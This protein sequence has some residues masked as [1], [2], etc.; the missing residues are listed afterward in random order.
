MV[1]F[2]GPTDVR[3]LAERLGVR[4]AKRWG[5]NFVVDAGTVRRIARLAKLTAGEHVLEVG[6]G[7]GSLTLA[8]LE[9]GARVTAIEIDPALAGA[10]PET[11]SGR[12]GEQAGMLAVIDGDAMKAGPGDV[13]NAWGGE[14]VLDP[15]TLVANLPY[16]VAVP[17]ILHALEEFLS[18]R[19]VLVMV[20][21]EVAD[22]VVAGPG[23][24]T[25]GIPSAKV[26]WYASAR[27]V[28]TVGRSAFW[29][30]PRVDSSLVLLERRETPVTTADRADVFRVVDAAFSQRRKGLRGALASLA[31]SASQAERALAAAGIDPLARGETLGIAEFARLAEEMPF[32]EGTASGTVGT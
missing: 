25:Y 32:P 27:Q 9:A 20:Q 16:N 14:S 7:L 12:A 19:R 18:L 8:L 28:G 4:P 2:L 17:V 22:R 29:P 3:L 11:V 26:A 10:L 21:S 31:G 24:R 13:R 5:Q 30:V 1:R 23:S 6:P 15:T